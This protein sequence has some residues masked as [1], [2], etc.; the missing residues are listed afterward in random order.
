MI[1]KPNTVSN[2]SSV[3][4]EIPK[5]PSIAPTNAGARIDVMRRGSI[6]APSRL[7]ETSDANV[8]TRMPTRFDPLA[9]T[10]G[11]PAITRSGTVR[12][13]PPPAIALITPAT[14][15]PTK[16]RMTSTPD[17]V[18]GYKVTWTPRFFETYRATA[19]A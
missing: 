7:K 10:P 18:A 14:A 15:P 5:A 16:R 6:H 12:A 8:E 4:C 3:S 1:S 19:I 2:V 11:T 9:A 13:D 17:T